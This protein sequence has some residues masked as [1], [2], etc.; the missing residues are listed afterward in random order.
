[1]RCGLNQSNMYS[2]RR[3]ARAPSGTLGSAPAAIGSGAGAGEPGGVFPGDAPTDDGVRGG[4]RG[5]ASGGGLTLSWRLL[6]IWPWPYLVSLLGL[7]LWAVV[8]VEEVMG[9]LARPRQDLLVLTRLMVLPL[10][11]RSTVLAV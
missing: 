9:P 8:S 7:G 2:T 1:M 11:S 6:V 5:G 3:A 10:E 4:V